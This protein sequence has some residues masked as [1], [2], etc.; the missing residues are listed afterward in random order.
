MTYKRL[1]QTIDKK[2][3]GVTLEP[4]E[5]NSLVKEIEDNPY[6]KDILRKTVSALMYDSARKDKS[7]S[8]RYR[9]AKDMSD[10]DAKELIDE[11]I[12]NHIANYQDSICTNRF[13]KNFS[14]LLKKQEE[15]Y[16]TKISYT[17]AKA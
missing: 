12:I 3:H 14:K 15:E 10:E 7:L 6:S 1:Y 11:V 9:Q 2:L 5:T 17:T 16:E 13:L 8:G 4:A